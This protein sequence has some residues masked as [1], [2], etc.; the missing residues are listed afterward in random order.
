MNRTPAPGMFAER[1]N[2]AAGVERPRARRLAGSSLHAVPGQEPAT[3]GDS[4]A[5]PALAPPRPPEQVPTQGSTPT[6]IPEPAQAAPQQEI[7]PE[8]AATQVAQPAPTPT[9]QETAAV[10]SVEVD[11]ATVKVLRSTVSEV[12]STQV[13]AGT[14]LSREAHEEL[15][16]RLTQDA[17]RDLGATNARAG[18]PSLSPGMRQA[19]LR[20][21]LDCLFG[22]GRFQYL[23]STPNVENIEIEGCDQVC[24]SFADGSV[25][26]QPPIFATDE[27]L[28]DEIAHL[29]RIAGAGERD[30]SPASPSLRMRLPDGSRLAADAWLC[31]RPSATIRVHRYVDTDLGEMQRLGAVDA[32]LVQ[33]L[34]AC[35]RAG[36][37]IV[38]AGDPSA[39]KTTLSRAILAALGPDVRIATVESM[40]EL[41]LHEMPDRHRRVW[42]TEAQPGGE[43]GADG[44]P[45]GQVSLSDLVARALQKNTQRIVVGETTGGAE[46]MAMI[47]A[48]Q[49][50]KG[51]LTTLHADNARDALDRIATLI[52]GARANTG[53]VYATRLVAQTVDVIV[54]VAFRTDP[55]ARVNE[56]F[57]DEVVTLAPSGESGVAADFTYVYE[58]GPDGRAIP[59]GQRPAWLPQLAGVGFD[60]GWLRPGVSSWPARKVSA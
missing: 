11:W 32:S 56:R 58:P 37:S 28:I 26:Y 35:I 4:P 3:S 24:L 53:E 54:H 22:A 50:G 20:A 21:V 29:A 27:E 33:F 43:R 8:Q 47:E 48:M 25:S 5:A 30:F 1:A 23:I 12:F 36:R 59:T 52:M 42:A 60:A 9:G 31:S 18:Q 49:A 40:Y 17:L 45:V 34:A 44:Y 6:T 10:A 38:V 41:G 14:R 19:L 55:V 15:I 7:T 39:G 51:C 57:V 46:V 16:I 13:P 2:A